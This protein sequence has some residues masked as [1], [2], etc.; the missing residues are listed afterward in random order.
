MARHPITG[1]ET[2]SRDLNL[3]YHGS[4]CVDAVE[5]FISRQEMDMITP[6]IISPT[7]NVTMEGFF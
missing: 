3:H 5:L 7:F 6:H 1:W 2:D 4:G